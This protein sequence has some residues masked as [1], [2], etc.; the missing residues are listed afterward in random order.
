EVVD[1]GRVHLSKGLVREAQRLARENVRRLA[2]LVSDDEPL[3]GIE[4]SAI[5]GFRDEVP[6]L[7]G[8]ELRGGA[9]ELAGRSLLLDEFLAREVDAGRLDATAFD[10]TPRRLLVHGHCHQ[11]ALAGMESTLRI[12]GLPAGHLVELI[13]SGCCGMAGSFGYEA[14]H[15]AVAMQIGELTLLPAIRAASPE[16]IIVA[17]GTSCRHQVLDGT[18]RRAVHPVEVL[19]AA[20]VERRMRRES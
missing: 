16:T 13:P 7:V 12:L 1:S 8:D 15:V 19:R 5:L 6:D 17:T 10:G 14:E 4:P 2:P 3:V 9:R 20:V 11:K 18:G